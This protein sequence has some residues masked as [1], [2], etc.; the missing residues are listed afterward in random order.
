M[1]H[2]IVPIIVYLLKFNSF[3]QDNSKYHQLDFRIQE[4]SFDGTDSLFGNEAISDRDEIEET[5]VVLKTKTTRQRQKRYVQQLSRKCLGKKL[6]L[7]KILGLKQT[8]LKQF[9][10][11]LLSF[12]HVHLHNI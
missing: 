1:N 10:L 11:L 5:F 2:I 3:F 6:F 7:V 8:F 12:S 9:S 4:F